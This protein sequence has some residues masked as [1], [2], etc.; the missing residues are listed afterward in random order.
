MSLDAPRRRRHHDGVTGAVAVP[1][2]GR[3]DHRAAVAPLR[4]ARPRAADPRRGRCRQVL[5]IAADG[6]ARRPTSSTGPACSSRGSRW[7]WPRSRCSSTPGAGGPSPPRA[8][9]SSRPSSGCGPSGAGPTPWPRPAPRR[10]PPSSSRTCSGPT[11]RRATSWSTWPP[12]RPVAGSAW[13]SPCGTTRPRGWGACS[14]RR[15]PGPAAGA[16]DIQLQRLGLEESRELVALLT[17]STDVDVGTWFE[18]SQGNPYLLG[19]L[20]RDPGARR[21]K[22]V[23]LAA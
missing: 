9:S 13:S 14:R 17:G 20:V 3:T 6:R 1:Y 21:V 4:R 22:D 12:P 16:R 23:L 2:I 19:E 18:Q 8:P 5:P 11:R 7:P 10:P 15:R